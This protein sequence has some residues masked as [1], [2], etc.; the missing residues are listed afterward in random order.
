MNFL[1]HYFFDKHQQDSYQ[2]LGAVL[3]DL[4]KNAD[5]NW[6]IYPQKHESV[7]QDNPIYSSIIRGWKRHLQ[8]DAIFHSSDFFYTHTAALKMLI[9]PILENTPVRPSFLAHIALELL[10]DHLILTQKLIS[11]DDF[12]NHLKVVDLDKLTDF[13]AAENIHE[14]QK[15]LRFYNGF[16]DNRYLFSYQELDNVSYALHRICLRIWDNP[17]SEETKAELTNKLQ[18]YKADLQVDFMRI[19]EEIGGRVN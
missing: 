14:S 9:K 8:V 13:L 12:Y 1:S 16:I 7:Y 15:F 5:K 4:V 10:L 2:V 19:F 11:A 6:N 3:P 18:L 17:F